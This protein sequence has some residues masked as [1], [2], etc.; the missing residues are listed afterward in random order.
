MTCTSSLDTSEGSGDRAASVGESE[1][2][3]TGLEALAQASRPWCSN[4]VRPPTAPVGSAGSRRW[5]RSAS[6]AAAASPEIDN[7]KLGVAVFFA[8][9]QSSLQAASVD[10]Y[11]K[12]FLNRLD[13]LHGGERGF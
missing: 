7:F 5:G 10:A 1:A 12:T 11:G 2:A 4:T 3:G 6:Y 9:S 13:T 8:P